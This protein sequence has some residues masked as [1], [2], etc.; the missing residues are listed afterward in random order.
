MTMAELNSCDTD[1]LTKLKTFTIWPF[2]D[3]C[4]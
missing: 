1:W 3:T 2:I 4:L